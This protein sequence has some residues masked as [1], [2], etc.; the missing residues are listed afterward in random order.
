[1]QGN[2]VTIAIKVPAKVENDEAAIE[3]LGGLD[4]IAKVSFS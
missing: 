4:E 1:M 3:R 2:T